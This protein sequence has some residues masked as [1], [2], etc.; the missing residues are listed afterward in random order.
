MHAFQAFWQAAKVVPGRLLK[1]DT[2]QTFFSHYY[3]GN[4]HW[5]WKDIVSVRIT[6]LCAKSRVALSDFAKCKIRG[7]FTR[8]K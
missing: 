1:T 2:V 4:L 8:S 7:S 5:N 3:A 6:I